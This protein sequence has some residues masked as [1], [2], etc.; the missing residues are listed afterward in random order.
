MMR[1]EG[2]YAIITEPGKPDRE[3]STFTCSHCCRVSHVKAGARA[4]DIGGLCKI[5]MGLV[6]SE[7]VGKGCDPLEEKLKREEAR[8]DALRSY[9]MA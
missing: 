6:C 5:C 9:G 1:R 2:G 3:A 8:Y 4:E 7:C